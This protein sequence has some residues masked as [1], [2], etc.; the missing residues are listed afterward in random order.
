MEAG[1][2]W[3]ALWAGLDLVYFTLLPATLSVLSILYYRRLRG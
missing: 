3:I 1:N 2:V